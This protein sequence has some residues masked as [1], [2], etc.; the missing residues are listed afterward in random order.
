M[1]YV[2]G[3]HAAAKR[4]LEASP[5][6]LAQNPNQPFRDGSI[7]I[8]RAYLC[9]VLAKIGDREGAKKHFAAAQDY[10]MATDETDLLEECKRLACV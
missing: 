4:E 7:S 2:E 3:D 1:A 8:A 10:L 6:I 5:G 9:C